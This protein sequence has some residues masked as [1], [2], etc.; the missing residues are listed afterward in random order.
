[1]YV[2]HYLALPTVRSGLLGAL[3]SYCLSIVV[4]HPRGYFYRNRR[5]EINAVRLCMLPRVCVFSVERLK[6]ACKHLHVERDHYSTNFVGF[7]PGYTQH[8]FLDGGRQMTSGTIF[9]PS[10]CKKLDRMHSHLVMDKLPLTIK[11]FFR[12]SKPLDLCSALH[13]A[14]NAILLP[15]TVQMMMILR[16]MV[17]DP[18]V[19][20]WS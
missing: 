8:A 11:L 15:V 12:L 2:D 4:T 6:Y 14:V 7:S 1:M 17:V 19:V 9:A 18:T 5:F 20:P 13:V 10:H 3:R 16:M